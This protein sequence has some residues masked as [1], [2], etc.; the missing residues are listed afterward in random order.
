MEKRAYG[1][2]PLAWELGL[3]RFGLDLKLVQWQ[4][5]CSCTSTLQV[6]FRAVA[7][8]RWTWMEVDGHGQRWTDMDRGGQTWTEVDR[9]GQRWMDMDRGGRTWMEVGRHGQRQMEVGRGRWRR[10]N[11]IV[12]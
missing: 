1:W 6:H 10:R 2:Q 12:P 4:V 8:G 5:Q 9:H 7:E 3:D 11:E